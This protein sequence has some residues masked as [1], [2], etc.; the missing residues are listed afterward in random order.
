MRTLVATLGLGLALTV[1][2][3]DAQTTISVYPQGTAFPLQLYALAPDSHIPLVTVN[4]WNV[5]H[6]YGWAD[7]SSG[8]D[9]LNAL[10]QTFAQNGI[11]GLP[12]LPS[13]IILEGVNCISP[14][15]CR[16]GWEEADIAGWI[17]ALAP[18]TNISYWDLP[19][20]LRYFRPT[21]WAIVQNYV[22]WTRSYDPELRPNYMYIPSNY[23]Q[24][25]VQNY[26]PYLDVIP[27]SAYADRADFPHAWI[28]WRM[29]ETIRGINLAGATIGRDY[30]NDQKTPV[31]IVQLFVGP[32][33]VIPSPEQ[34]YH[35]FWQLIASGAQGI[36]VFSYA[37]GQI[38]VGGALIPNWNLL[39]QAASQITGPEQ[40]GDMVLYGTTVS[41]V[42]FSVLAGPTETDS[43]TPTGYETPVQF[44]S[45]HLFSQQWNGAT[46][47][48]AVNSTEQDVTAEV[49]NVPTN[50]ATAEVLF[51][52]R[53]VPISDGSFGDTFSAWGVNIYKIED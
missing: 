30:L 33:G 28:R 44:P 41:D 27:A 2:A 52:N 51:Q 31:G 24:L 7:G 36:F 8:V 3:A 21:E 37:R 38:D 26:V 16:T 9:S 25:Q 43:F 48:I 4:G 50:S 14:P 53:T 34:T 22:A 39:Q 40:L 5:G 29:E 45:I 47:I 12:A 35:D 15:H 20:E 6:R 23:T 1:S 19:E 11:E 18:N 10:L 49:S 42:T 32:N 13:L 46:Y 17:H